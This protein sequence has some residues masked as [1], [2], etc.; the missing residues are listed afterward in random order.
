MNNVPFRA[1]LMKSVLII[2]DDA[3]SRSTLKE[4]FEYLHYEIYEA[5]NGKD[6]I[7]SYRRIPTH[8]VL[9]DIFMPEKDGLETIRELKQEF[10]DV[11]IIA[12]SAHDR[13]NVDFL[14]IAGYL[15][16]MHCVRK[17]FSTDDIIKVISLTLEGGP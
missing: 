5:C 10:P 17:P 6:G 4:I 9:T 11:K 1:T 3:S 13:G 12:M 15:G 16:A 2:D 14:R 7:D 8:I